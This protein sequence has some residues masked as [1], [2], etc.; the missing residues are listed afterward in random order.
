MSNEF[1]TQPPI[2]TPAVQPSESMLGIDIGYR[3]Q[4]RKSMNPGIEG[5]SNAPID[6]GRDALSVNDMVDYREQ[7]D[8]SRLSPQTIEYLEVARQRMGSWVKEFGDREMV[9]GVYASVVGRRNEIAESDLVKVKLLNELIPQSQFELDEALE[10]HDM[11]REV[12]DQAN[13]L[14]H[15]QYGVVDN[16]AEDAK[17]TQGLINDAEKQRRELRAYRKTIDDRRLELLRHSLGEVKAPLKEEER[18]RWVIEGMEYGRLG[19]VEADPNFEPGSTYELTRA[20]AVAAHTVRL[21]DEEIARWSAYIN[22]QRDV[23]DAAYDRMRQ[24]E[25]VQHQRHEE[26]LRVHTDFTRTEFM[27]SEAQSRYAEAGS[28]SLRIMGIP[29]ED[30]GDEMTRKLKAAKNKKALEDERLKQITAFG[31][32]DAGESDQIVTQRLPAR[33]RSEVAARII[34]NGLGLGKQEIFIGYPKPKELE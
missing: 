32:A 21:Y 20:I 22:E 28:Y 10:N 33:V 24:A 17:A 26:L 29:D 34:I 16:H 14:L 9:E 8:T 31:S 7:L 12:R 4:R 2:D 13:E 6:T 25:M 23:R 3:G 27:V 5:Q 15:Q 11:Q 1:N 30:F 18:Q 19:T